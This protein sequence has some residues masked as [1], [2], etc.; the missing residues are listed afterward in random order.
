[1]RRATQRCHSPGP[2]EHWR[3]AILDVDAR[4][5]ARLVWEQVNPSPG[6]D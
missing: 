3:A 1:L 4:T 5:G 2:L 6:A